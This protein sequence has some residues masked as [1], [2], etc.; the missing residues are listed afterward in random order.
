MDKVYIGT[1]LKFQIVLQSSGFSMVDDDFTI[2]LRNGSKKL[3]FDKNQLVHDEEDSFYLCFDTKDI[4][5]GTVELVATAHVPDDD[6]DD[7]IR[8]EVTKV[9]LI[10]INS[11]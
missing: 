3:V 11:L 5:T 4:G 6:F 10:T 9:K 8:D 7:G 1:E 2:E